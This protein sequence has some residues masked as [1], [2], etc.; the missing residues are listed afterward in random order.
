M[1][2]SQ[3]PQEAKKILEPNKY[4]R[5]FLYLFYLTS[6]VSVCFMEKKPYR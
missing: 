1:R 3:D 6:F 4:A 5:D 2:N